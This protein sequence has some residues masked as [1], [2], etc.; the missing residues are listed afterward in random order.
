MESGVDGDERVTVLSH[1]V[2][3]RTRRVLDRL[4]L[5]ALCRVFGF[6]SW[7]AAAPYSCRP[8]KSQVVELANAIRPS[9]AVEIGCGLGDILSRI[10]SAERIGIDIDA[11][12][13]RAA[14]FLHPALV[15]IHGGANT[16]SQLLPEGKI[17][18]C[19]ITVNW[20]HAMSADTLEAM[21]L[22][23]LKRARYLIVDSIDQNGPIS[24][25]H[26]HD[27][28]FLAQNAQQIATVPVSG[29]PRNLL[30]F[31]VSK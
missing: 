2:A 13:I 25:R 15:W 21:L 22:P 29:E 19:L 10:D 16:A 24:Y 9:L 31:K 17:V 8:Y 7:H 30:L 14:K 11:G 27:F 20:I 5:S 1:S 4:W 18:D 6:D 3:A 12:V 28:S 26:K 23:L